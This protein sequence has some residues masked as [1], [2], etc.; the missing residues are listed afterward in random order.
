MFNSFKRTFLPLEVFWRTF[1]SQNLST[2]VL[3]ALFRVGHISFYPPILLLLFLRGPGKI[4]TM[5]VNIFMEVTVSPPSGLT[6]FE[7]MQPSALLCEFLRILCCHWLSSWLE[8]T[9]LDVNSFP[10]V[11]RLP[12]RLLIKSQGCFIVAAPGPLFIKPSKG[13]DYLYV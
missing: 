3:F 1:Y 5:K 10:C 9:P 6:A 4:S 12:M 8:L 13:G 7:S 11:S 2:I